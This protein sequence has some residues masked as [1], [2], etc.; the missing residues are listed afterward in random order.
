MSQSLEQEVFDVDEL[1][2]RMMG[3][4]D[5]AVEIISEFVTDLSEQIDSLKTSIAEGDEKVIAR[6]IHTI[7]GAS[8]NVGAKELERLA[9]SAEKGGIAKETERASAFVSHLIEQFE[10]FKTRV[11]E[12]GF[13]NVEKSD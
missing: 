1:L 5:L 4:R 8:A 7:K 10:V 11:H 12:S 9:R 6:R 2:H 13:L 3:D